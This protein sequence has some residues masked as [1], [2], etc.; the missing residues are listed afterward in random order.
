VAHNPPPL[1]GPLLPPVAGERHALPFVIPCGRVALLLLD[2]RGERDVFRPL[3]P[4]LGDRQWRA[5]LDW[6]GRLPGNIQALG[7]VTPVPIVAMDPGG[8]S[9]SL[10]KHRTDDELLYRDGRAEDLLI[11]QKESGGVL[12]IPFNLAGRA[13]DANIGAFRVRSID[14]LR[15]QWSHPLSQ[16][17]QETILRTI[18][19]ARFVNR[20]PGRARRSSSAATFTSPGGLK[21]TSA[22]WR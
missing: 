2:G 19:Q 4:I 11:L 6:L 12:D 20:R 14:D 1:F 18:A 15:D 9:Q 10:F 16:P 17:E 8:L 22:N 7:C 5:A 3:Y 13:L 21:S